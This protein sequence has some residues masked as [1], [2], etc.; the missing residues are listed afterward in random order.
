MRLMLVGS[1]AH[2]AIEHHYIAILEKEVAA[3]DVFPA[4]DLFAEYYRGLGH[5]IWFRLGWAPIYRHINQQLLARVATFQP[6]IVWV[7]KGTEVFP[8]TLQKIKNQGVK[9]VNYNPDHPFILSSRGSGNAN[10]TRSVSLYDLHFCYNQ[11][12]AREIETK[13]TI[14]TAALPFGY[15]YTNKVFEIV[16]NAPEILKLAFIGNPDAMR[17]NMI[18]ALCEAGVP[19]DVFGNN[20]RRFLHAKDGLAL[21]TPLY[22]LDF[23]VAMRQYRVQ[24]NVF[25]P[26]NVGSHNMRSFEIPGIGGIML[27]P[28]SPE[29]RSFFEADREIV[30]YDSIDHAI[31]QA[32]KLLALPLAEAQSIRKNAL[33]RSKSGAYTYADRAQQALM[34]LKKLL[35]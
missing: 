19:I 10:V 6:D 29:H 34:G 14:S 3:L 21:H 35:N 28:D 33:Q 30:L 12:L 2:W 18:N 9:I 8:E 22:G 27:A 23:W 7:W 4:P 26:H 11:I 16:E 25:R 15:S 20:W 1:Q 24:L 13:Y 31:Q 5:K 17:V 32:Q